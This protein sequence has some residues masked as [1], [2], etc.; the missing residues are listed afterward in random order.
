VPPAPSLD[1]GHCRTDGT[2]GIRRPESIGRS[3]TLERARRILQSEEGQTLVEYALII[4]VV[5]LTLVAA[6]TGISDALTRAFD[7]ITS[8]LSGVV[9]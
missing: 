5:A 8:A 2:G 3:K 1:C 6:L 9:S 4:G 7:A